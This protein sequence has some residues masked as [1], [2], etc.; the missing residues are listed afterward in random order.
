MQDIRYHCPTYCVL[1]IKKYL[2]K[3]FSHK[4]W[5]FENGDYNE[6]RQAVSDYDWNT[7]IK[8]DV[9]L[10]ANVLTHTL[11]NLSEQYIPHK[12]VT[13]RPQDLPWIDDSIRKLM[14]KKRN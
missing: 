14:R 1:K 13:I 4:I 7:I 2:A 3:A 12:N 9:N 11:I 10:Y 8:D 5:L 6:F